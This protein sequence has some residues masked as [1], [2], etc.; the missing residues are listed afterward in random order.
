VTN[1]TF[2]DEIKKLETEK[3]RIQDEFNIQRAKMKELF[4][5][6]EGNFFRDVWMLKSVLYG[7]LCKKFALKGRLL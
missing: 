4:L 7:V 1:S 2:S 5:Q 6:K 3:K